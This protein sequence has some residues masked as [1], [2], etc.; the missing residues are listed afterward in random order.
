MILWHVDD[1]HNFLTLF[2]FYTI[3]KQLNSKFT[4]LF[5]VQGARKFYSTPEKGVT[6]ANN[7]N[8]NF[9]FIVFVFFKWLVVQIWIIRRNS[10]K[11][12]KSKSY[13]KRF[14]NCAKMEHVGLY[15][16]ERE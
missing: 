1:F 2:V 11:R 4:V 9:A 6:C 13:S 14:D 12:T 3:L 5:H 15:T 7:M 16:I 10:I 8:I